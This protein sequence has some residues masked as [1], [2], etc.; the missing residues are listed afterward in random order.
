MKVIKISPKGQITIPQMFRYLC[1]TGY[2]AF[3]V[4]DK[5]MVLRPIEIQPV[6]TDEE[7]IQELLAEYERDKSTKN[8]STS[9]K[10][11]NGGT[12]GV[13]TRDLHSDSVAF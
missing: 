3:T 10:N 6:K 7:I 1:E 9:P 2:L 13:R 12:D 11:I 8:K 5:T 4:E